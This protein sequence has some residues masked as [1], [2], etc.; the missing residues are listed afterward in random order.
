MATTELED[1]EIDGNF[2]SVTM[3]GA[4]INQTKRKAGYR[5]KTTILE[6]KENDDMCDELFEASKSMKMSET[7]RG[8]ASAMVTVFN[9]EATSVS[10]ALSETTN[11]VYFYLFNSIN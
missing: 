6:E 3:L 4:T 8:V 5:A 1:T 10:P 11:K 7:T 9:L 2:T